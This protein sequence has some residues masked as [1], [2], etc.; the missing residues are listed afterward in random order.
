MSIYEEIGGEAAVSAAVDIFYAKVL[1]DPL[2]APFFDHIEM[3]GQ[4]RK[5]KAFFATIFRGDTAGA[6]AYMRRSHK[7]LVKN[8][9]LSDEHFDAVA[10]HLQATLEQLDVP[11]HLV[12]VIMKSATG[13]K[14]SVLNRPAA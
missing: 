11:T 9:G 3:G 4:S 8:R 1:A 7:G 2:L 14:N 10:A 6:D 5:Q 12:A 13:L